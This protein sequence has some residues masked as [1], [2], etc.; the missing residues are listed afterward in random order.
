MAYRLLRL[1]ES[2]CAEAHYQYLKEVIHKMTLKPLG[3]R[4]LVLGGSRILADQSVKL[5]RPRDRLSDEFV[6]ALVGL[7]RTFVEAVT[8]NDD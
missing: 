5:P 6:K 8:G 2:Y 4:V 1:E 3:D 7:R